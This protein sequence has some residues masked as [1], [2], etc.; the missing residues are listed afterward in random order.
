MNSFKDP[1]AQGNSD[2]KLV[3]T[4]KLQSQQFRTPTKVTTRVTT[5]DIRVQTI[6]SN[7]STGNEQNKINAN[8]ESKCGEDWIT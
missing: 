2:S 6:H 8:S 4:Y 3:L 1:M 5:R 7:Y